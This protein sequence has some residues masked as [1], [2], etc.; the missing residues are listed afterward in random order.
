MR[1]IVLAVTLL[2]LLLGPA[3]SPGALAD[4]DEAPTLTVLGA[5]VNPIKATV[6]SEMILWTVSRSPLCGRPARVSPMPET[7]LSA[8]RATMTRILDSMRISVFFS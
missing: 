7:N 5:R 1:R 6:S 3:A 4:E 2:A 8:K